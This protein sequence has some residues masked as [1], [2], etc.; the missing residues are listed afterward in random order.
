MYKEREEFISYINKNENEKE[1]IE[2]A[3]KR[4][5][6][7]DIK[8]HNKDIPFSYVPLFIN[9]EDYDFFTDI[10]KMLIKILSKI[11]RKYIE[12]ESYRKLFPFSKTMENLILLPCNYENIIPVGRYDLFLNE[13]DNSYKFCEFNTDGSGGMSRDFE[14][15]S[16]I[17]ANTTNYEFIKKY[18]AKPFDTIDLIAEELIKTYNTDKNKVDNPTFCI[19]DFT[20]EGVMSDFQ[21]FIKAF[22]NKGIDARFTDVRNLYFDGEKLI[23]KTD[24]KKIDAIYRRLVTSVLI[25]RID[26][27]KDLIKAVENEKVVLL[28]HFR[29]SI[30]HSKNISVV[31]HDKKT[32]EFLTEEETEFINLHMPLSYYL[33]DNNLD[34]KLK[35]NIIANKDKW[36]IKPDEGFGSFG[37]Y[38]GKDETKESWQNIIN[39]KMN[40][41]YIV[42]EFIDSEKVNFLNYINNKIE[43]YN[44][45]IGVYHCNDKVTGFYS[46]GGNNGIIDFNHDGI[47]VS[48]VRCF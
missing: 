45:M 4:I 24:G 39:D 28:G 17:L 15:S 6:N 46:R 19:T 13:S 18:N 9:K 41:H 32:K 42:E 1:H 25:E 27:C 34:N 36:I 11:T 21:R 5:I 43:N 20:E 38:C 29:T 10:T 48:T 44:L 26:E 14:I 8:A 40:H 2:N 12:D 31:I 22:K 33:S 3:K 37:I 47:L 30:A 16:A 7:S 23:D 35:E